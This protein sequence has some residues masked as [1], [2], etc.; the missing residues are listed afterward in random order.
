MLSETIAKKLRFSFERGELTNG[1]GQIA[2][3]VG[4]PY[5]GVANDFMQA[6]RKISDGLASTLSID[7]CLKSFDDD[8][9]IVKLGKLAI[10]SV[11]GH[12]EATSKLANLAHHQ[13]ETRM[14][15][16]AALDKTWLADLFRRLRSPIHER[17]REHL[18]DSVAFIDFN[19]D[20]CLEHYLFH[21]VKRAFSIDDAAAARV[22]AG[23]LVVHPYGRIGALPWQQGGRQHPFGGANLDLVDLSKG[24]LTYTEQVDDAD[25]LRLLSELV[26]SPSK[27]VFLGFGFHQQNMRMLRRERT[28]NVPKVLATAYDESEGNIAVYRNFLRQLMGIGIG[29]T[30]PRPDIVNATCDGFIHDWGK[31]I[32]EG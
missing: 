14:A 9:R 15:A 2:H 28:I 12:A 1:D 24:I 25:H 4:I 11:I 32:L 8:Q 27:I 13:P 31:L 29:T 16:L 23:L 6:A 22:M 30:G 17:E 20:R 5:S 10:V 26:E 19:Y 3:L 21:A 7:D 18:F